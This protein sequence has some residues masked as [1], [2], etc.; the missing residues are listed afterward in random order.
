MLGNTLS[1]ALKIEETRYIKRF[2]KFL[3][4]QAY[5]FDPKYFITCY[6]GKSFEGYDFLSTDD[7]RKRWDRVQ[8]RRTHRFIKKQINKCFGNV[9]MVFCIERHKNREDPI[10]GEMK[11]SFHTH[12]YLGEVNDEF[13]ESPNQYLMPLFYK[14]DD[15]GVPINMRSVDIENLKLLLINACVRQAQWIGKHPSS[16]NIQPIE[17]SE[18]KTTFHY[19][20]K[21]INIEDDLNEVID[22][23]NSDFYNPNTK[24][25]IK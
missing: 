14:E 1:Y 4:E 18:F 12:L 5:E 21:Q 11:G 17:P 24:E 9:P 10:W 25:K 22:W 15:I 8:V 3:T 7:Y 23:E 16:L 20:L 2:K 19:G 13:I 6:Y